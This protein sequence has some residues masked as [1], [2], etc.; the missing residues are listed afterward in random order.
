[1]AEPEALAAAPWLQLDEVLASSPPAI[2][3]RAR[4]R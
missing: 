4:T 1:V 3:A 2:L